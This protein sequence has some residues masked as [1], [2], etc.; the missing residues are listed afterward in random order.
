MRS[1]L[2]LAFAFDG[3][4]YHYGYGVCGHADTG[5]GKTSLF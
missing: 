5:M 1:F 2:K 4:P 3:G